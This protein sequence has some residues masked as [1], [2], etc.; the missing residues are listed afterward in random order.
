MLLAIYGSLI[1][2]TS[3]KSE[4]R[5]TKESKKFDTVRTSIGVYPTL[6]NTDG[7]FLVAFIP[8][9]GILGGGLPGPDNKFT[10]LDIAY[11]DGS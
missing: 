7:S 5:E 10:S 2:A 8:S 9:T 1:L 4:D 6:A 3:E 11:M